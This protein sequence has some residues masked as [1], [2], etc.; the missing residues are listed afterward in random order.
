MNTI[1]LRGRLVDHPHQK[2]D[3]KTAQQLR[4]LLEGLSGAH[5]ATVRGALAARPGL[6]EMFAVEFRRPY[7]HS[8]SQRVT[9]YRWRE[10]AH[11]AGGRF[12]DELVESGLIFEKGQAGQLMPFLGYLE[13]QIEYRE[14]AALNDARNRTF[15]IYGFEDKLAE[16]LVYEG[17]ELTP[18]EWVR[19]RESVARYF[20]TVAARIRE[21]QPSGEFAFPDPQ[22]PETWLMPQIR[23]S[24]TE[25]RAQ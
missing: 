22:D 25:E 18:D 2:K 16:Q 23:E 24:R 3:H 13:Q 9:V 12:R 5:Q 20:E 21:L 10:H 19:R 15:M 1:T 14:R 7:S 6:A 8:E 17:E 11:A 4:L